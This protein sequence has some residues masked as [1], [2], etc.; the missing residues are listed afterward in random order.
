MTHL[1]TPSGFDP[2]IPIEYAKTP[3]ASWYTD[4]SYFQLEKERVFKKS[5]QAVGYK[6]QLQKAGDYFS[7]EF[8]GLSYLVVLGRDMQVRAFYNVCRH[9][10]AGL[11]QGSGCRQELVCPYHGWTYKLDGNLASAPRMNGACDF[12]LA[13]NGLFPIQVE[14]W[15][16]FIWLKFGEESKPVHVSLGELDRR[17]NGMKTDQL[18]F[19]CRKTYEIS[20]N[21]KVYVDN[22][23][24]GGYHVPILHRDL[25]AN[26]NIGSYRTEIFDRYSIQSC[27][28]KNDERIGSHAL[29]AWIYPNFMINRY[30]PMMDTNWVIPLS[31]E[32]TLTVFD[33]YFTED[34]INN[35]EFIHNALAASEQVQK[36]D[37]FISESVQRGLASGV[38]VSGRYA[39]QVE[40]GEYHFHQ[41]LIQDLTY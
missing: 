28:G 33:Y 37:V 7:G 8:L 3:P 38:Y 10:A 30:G 27:N 26:L 39:P 14:V 21:W 16:L 24:D 31:V 9:H 2:D 18:K 40:N 32:K 11:V 35:H 15:G 23:L 4:P 29:Y 36:E 6:A 19:Y 41:I 22:Y 5:W 12:K 34:L 1:T 13:D 25:S 20:C 17:L